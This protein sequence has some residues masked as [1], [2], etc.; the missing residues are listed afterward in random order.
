MT[1]AAGTT[2]VKERWG[3]QLRDARIDRQLFQATVATE[4]GIT[5]ATVSRAESGR[6][7][8]DVFHRMAAYY[9][10]TLEAGDGQR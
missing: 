10:I 7:S 1:D 4:V 8:L 3:Q 6:G 2:G 5:E 9:G